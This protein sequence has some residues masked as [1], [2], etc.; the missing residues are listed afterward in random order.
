VTPPGAWDRLP[1]AARVQIPPAE[2][3]R[4]HVV[5]DTEEE[6]DWHAPY[7][8]ANTSVTAMRHISRVQTIFDRFGI[9]PT[10]VVDYPVASQPGGYE[11]LL[12]IAA[13][14]GCTIGAHLHPWVNPPFDETVSVAHSFT[15]N[16]PPTVQ[17][18][19]IVALCDAIGE[20]LATTPRMFK[21]GRYGLG[22]DTVEVLEELGF[23]IDGSICPR[24]DFSDQLGPSF[25]GFDSSLF[26]LTPGLLEIPCT[27][28]YVGWSGALRPALHR[29]ASSA[30]LARSRAVGVFA[31]LGVTNQVM[32]SPEGNELAEMQALTQALV[33]RGVRHLTLSFH[34]PSVEPGHT[35]YVRSQQDLDRFLRTIE[36]YCEFFM[37]AAGGRPITSSGT[38][39]WIQSFVEPI[40]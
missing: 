31:R 21:A 12:E 35:P 22:C 20:H 13:R 23:E 33:A 7:A 17:R 1:I 27:V 36:Q 15:G 16:L 5:I 18:A 3:P 4:L 34:S 25:A 40:V 29:L 19:K 30:A 14:G 11:P 26:Y 32:L 24:F 28:D 39:S 2:A 6:F 9:A 38:R 10:Y 37:K 8:R